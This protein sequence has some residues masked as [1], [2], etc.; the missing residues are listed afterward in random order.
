M[1]EDAALARHVGE[2]G[3][4]LELELHRTPSDNQCPEAAQVAKRREDAHA[5]RSAQ[6]EKTRLCDLTYRVMSKRY[7]MLAMS[8]EDVLDTTVQKELDENETAHMRSQATNRPRSF[9][10]RQDSGIGRA[11]QCCTL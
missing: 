9:P 2:H 7:S 5:R 8:C 11:M 6:L 3:C 10:R 4:S 1:A